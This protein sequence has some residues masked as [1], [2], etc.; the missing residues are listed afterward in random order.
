MMSVFI[1]QGLVDESLRLCKELCHCSAKPIC[2]VRPIEPSGLGPCQRCYGAA[3]EQ[4]GVEK[5]GRIY[6]G[7]CTVGSLVDCKRK[8]KKKTDFH[9]F[10]RRRRCCWSCVVSRRRWSPGKL[11]FLAEKCS[12]KVINR[13]LIRLT[14][15]GM[16]LFFQ[17]VHRTRTRVI[18][19]TH[20]WADLLWRQ[21][22]HCTPFTV[23]TTKTMNI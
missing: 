17:V 8:E 9:P 13:S 6:G 4:M 23:T 10:R 1:S 15:P 14:R 22:R 21:L 19:G 20:P 11:P 18:K 5:P 2:L 16:W 3:S 12:H 7:E